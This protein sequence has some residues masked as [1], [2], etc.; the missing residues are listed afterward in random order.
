MDLKIAD[1]QAGDILLCYSSMTAGEKTAIGTG[2]SHVAIALRG[3]RV[4]EA[5]NEGVQI[6]SVGKLLED[7]DHIAVLRESENSPLWGEARV[8]SLEKF[9]DQ[10]KGKRFNQI[11]LARVPSRKDVYRNDLMDRVRG[12]FEGTTA[13]VLSG[14]DVYFC[15]ELITAAFIHVGIIEQSAA[16]VFTP[17]TFSPSDIAKDK[18]F[19]FFYGYVKSN[20]S[21]VVPDEDFFRTNI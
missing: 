8:S 7:Y 5:T 21:Y 3:E 17:E 6:V 10:V 16:V 14:R 4:L 15:S 1:I 13:A 9:A 12:Y 19:G 2:Y 11:G 18:I 20:P